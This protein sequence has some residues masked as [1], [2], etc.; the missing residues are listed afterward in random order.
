MSETLNAKSYLGLLRKSGIVEEERL[1]GSLARLVSIAAGKSVSLDQL[2]AHFLN[3]GI[4][5]EW[6]SDQLK[7]GRHKGFFLGQYRLLR[8]LGAG[9]MSAV[10][11]AQ[12]QIA[13]HLRAV[14]VLPKSR[15]ADKSYLERFYLEGRAAAALRHPNIAQIV[16]LGNDNDVHYMVMEYV[17]G[18]DLEKLVQKNG[19]LDYLVALDY[20]RQTAEALQHAHSRNVIHR[21]IKP[22][23][24]LVTENGS[25]VKVLDLGLAL[26]TDGQESL[27]VLHDE[28]VMGTA[29]YLSPEQA[30]DSHRVDHRA[31]IYSLGCTFYFMLVGHPPFPT[32][33]IAQRVAKHQTVDPPELTTLRPDC[34]VQV[35]RL[36]HKMMQKKPE[37]R[38]AD[39]EILVR[40]VKKLKAALELQNKVPT[41]NGFSGNALT[42]PPGST[43][44]E[45]IAPAAARSQNRTQSPGETPQQ[46]ARAGAKQ[47][48]PGQERPGRAEAV[49]ESQGSVKSAAAS[50]SLAA[51]VPLVPAHP[52]GKDSPSDPARDALQFDEWEASPSLPKDAATD[53]SFIHE[54]GAKPGEMESLA[55]LVTAPVP[56]SSPRIRVKK[57]SSIKTTLIVSGLI[58]LMFAILLVV[59][60]FLSSSLS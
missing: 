28:K 50:A 34:P 56:V 18:T 6:Q 44:E 20:L 2:I 54:V 7:A 12:H 37:D 17:D 24:L 16:D 60:Y 26:F 40:A 4:I 35:A 23:N 38:F 57:S 15:V 30:I 49:V 46:F 8:L 52:M 11:L 48:R 32:G 1:K 19:P 36:C 55:G 51:T 59:L 10:Y 9:G 31:D 33:T 39:C 29:D 41:P 14:K 42:R 5:T 13:K 53:F 45:I 21:D 47:E 22:A 25:K 3:E 27:T 43:A 58:A